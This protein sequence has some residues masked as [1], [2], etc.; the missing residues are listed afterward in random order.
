MLG[1]PAGDYNAIRG[2]P[3]GFDLPRERCTRVRGRERW[4]HFELDGDRYRYVGLCDDITH[5]GPTPQELSRC[6]CGDPNCRDIEQRLGEVDAV[7]DSM[8]LGW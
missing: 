6:C 5:D 7:V 1:S 4:W 3:D 8:V 2:V